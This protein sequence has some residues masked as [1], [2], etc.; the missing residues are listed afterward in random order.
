MQH[1]HTKLP[2]QKLMLRQIEWGV[3]RCFLIF[4][5]KKKVKSS[6]QHLILNTFSWTSTWTYNK[7]KFIT[8]QTVDA[9][10]CSILI[11]HKM[12]GTGLSNTF[13]VWFTRKILFMLYSI[14]C[15]NFIVWLN[16]PCQ[17][18][19]NMCISV[20]CCAACDIITFKTNL[21][22]LIKPFSFMIKSVKKNQKFKCFKNEISF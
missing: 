15:P 8:I 5:K 2:Y 14:N 17:I 10:I 6:G 20:V 3:Q 18:L 13:F 12:S 22:F 21:S 19:S 7:S 11:S 1:V 9:K 16:L 4:F